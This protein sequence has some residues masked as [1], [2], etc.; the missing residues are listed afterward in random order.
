MLE[1]HAAATAASL[2][3]EAEVE[4]LA[5]LQAELAAAR[6]RSDAKR[7]LAVNEEFHF[8]V[9]NAAC[10]PVLVDVIATLWLHS[11]P[12]LSFFFRAARELRDYS[13]TQNRNNLALVASL[14]HRDPEGARHAIE[15]EIV[16]GSRLL[17]RLMREAKWDETAVV[18]RPHPAVRRPHGRRGDAPGTACGGAG[19]LIKS[20]RPA[21][22]RFERENGR[23]LR[24]G[25]DIGGTFTDIVLLGPDG[26]VRTAKL[27]STPDDYGRA[28]LD[29]L[30]GERARTGAAPEPI[31]EIVHGT[32]VATNAILEQ[33][34][35][36]VGLIT[37]KGFRDVLEIR[38]VRLP[39]L[40]DI[41]WRK[42]E[43]LVRRERRLEVDERVGPG[44]EVRQP[45]DQASTRAA[46]ERLKALGCESVAVCL[47]HS[48]ANAEHELA[49]GELLQ[50]EF[51][52]VSL[53][54]RV[55]PELKEY[56]RTATTVRGRI[57]EAGGEPVPG[58]SA[59]E[60]GCRGR[61]GA[62]ARD[63]VERRHLLRPR[64][65]GEPGADHRERPGR[66][67]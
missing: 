59:R 10:I 40:Y 65:G 17:D 60:P 23:M 44:G 14:R 61:A 54:C 21:P 42:P 55:L 56:E 41:T 53:S 50:G 12:T 57:R 28:I 49:V 48:Y 52:F 35:A 20:A 33:K 43:P 25:A 39:V 63:A 36:K 46:V 13:D 6:A 26:A 8:L 9:Y 2:I 64:G 19:N 7:I 58:Q 38:R 31:A 67:E 34:G 4:R 51:P 45:L 62:A 11:A 24:V 3:T 30:R 15:A 1:G 66:R 47:L 18:P 5:A 29:G 27:L 37:T 16:E 22:R 32:T